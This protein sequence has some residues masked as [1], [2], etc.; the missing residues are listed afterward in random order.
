MNMLVQLAVKKVSHQLTLGK[1]CEKPTL[2]TVCMYPEMHYVI[3]MLIETFIEQSKHVKH[4]MS[5]WIGTQ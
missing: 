1:K 3:D 4:R 2:F 5:Q